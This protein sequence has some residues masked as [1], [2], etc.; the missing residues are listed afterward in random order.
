MWDVAHN[1]FSAFLSVHVGYA[2]VA[3]ALYISSFFA[4]G[5]RWNLFLNAM[6]AHTRLIE[7]TLANLTSI[8]VNNVTPA[9]RLGGEACRIFLIQSRERVSYKTATLSSLYDR[10]SEIPPVGFLVVLSLPTL[11]QLVIDLDRYRPMAIGAIVLVLI[12]VIVYRKLPRLRKAWQKLI[13]QLSTKS[14]SGKTFLLG[15]GTST[16]IWL[17]DLLR[18]FVIATA[19]GIHLNISQL[20]TLVVFTIFGGLAP[21]IGGLGVIEG[22]LVAGLVLFGVNLEIAIA[23]TALERAI[24]YVFGAC[25]GGIAFLALGGKKIVKAKSLSPGGKHP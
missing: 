8:F 19:F 5:F 1:A 20:A 25:V 14:I 15:V 12:A 2:F 13:I 16:F 18:L 3:L 6:G 24:S 7:T 10:L 21:T 11:R 22:S 17:E 4:V 23:I 9:S